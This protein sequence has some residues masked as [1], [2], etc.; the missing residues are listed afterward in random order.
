MPGQYKNSRPSRE[1]TSQK[2]R[3]RASLVAAASNLVQAGKQPTVSEAAQAADISRATAYR[4]FPTQEMLLAEVALFSAGGPLF[5]ELDPTAPLP[6]AVGQLVRRVGIWAY[7][8]ETA[9]RTLMRL[10][11]YPHSGVRRP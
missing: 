5:A 3:T 6:E 11:L 9:L 8:N 10:S 4:Y 1:R 2:S 7:A